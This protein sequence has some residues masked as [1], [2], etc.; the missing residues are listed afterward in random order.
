M[1]YVLVL[2]DHVVF[3]ALV[4][5]LRSGGRRRRGDRRDCLGLFWLCLRGRS[6]IGLCQIAFR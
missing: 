4:R 6:D 5:G 2:R 1:K 3:V